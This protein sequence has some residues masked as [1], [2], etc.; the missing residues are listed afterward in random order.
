MSTQRIRKAES[1]IKDAELLLNHGR[2]DSC[3]SRCYYAMYHALI[4][5]LEQKGVR[6]KS[7]EHR[8]V[9]GEFGKE[10]VYRKK[11][12]SREI[13]APLYD[14]QD[15]RNEADYN[16]SSV[17]HKKAKRIFDKSRSLWNILSKGIK[18]A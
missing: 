17:S 11:V 6:S 8:F 4:A 9:L 16:V 1:F 12:F 5:L 14:I 2:Y 7:W 13:L 3:V 10:L 15:E 18:H